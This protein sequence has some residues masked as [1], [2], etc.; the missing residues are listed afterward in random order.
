MEKKRL[1]L[2]DLNGES[3]GKFIQLSERDAFV[4]A[5]MSS[6]GDAFVSNNISNAIKMSLVFKCTLPESQEEYDKIVHDY[7]KN[8]LML[9]AHSKAEEVFEE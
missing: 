3:E 2:L 7:K 5:T 6:I 9:L 4:I 1:D 8:V